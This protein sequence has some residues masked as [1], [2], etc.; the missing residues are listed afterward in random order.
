MRRYV[1]NQLKE[2]VIPMLEQVSGVKF[3][4]DRLLRDT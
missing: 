4:I 1:V 2:E 3:D